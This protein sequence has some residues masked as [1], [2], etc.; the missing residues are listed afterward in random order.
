MFKKNQHFRRLFLSLLSAILTW[1]CIGTVTVNAEPRV[2]STG[3]SLVIV[4]DPG[5]GGVNEG[6]TQNGFLEKEMTLATANAM[7]DELIKYDN[8]E[9]YMTRTDDTDY[10]LK[11]RAEFAASVD[12]DFM[13]SLHYNASE[14]HTLF[15]S[16]IWISAFAPY[17]AYGYQFGYCY[18]KEMEELGIVLRGIKTRLGDD[19][20][21]YYGVIRE[22]AHLSVPAVIIEHCHVD[23]PRDSVYCA[24]K[25]DWERFGRADATA[26]AKYFGLSSSELGVDYS[27]ESLNLPAVKEN[28]KVPNTIRDKT[29]PDICSI[30]LIEAN[31]DTGEVSIQ[32]TATDYDSPLLYYDY[33]IDGG[34]TYSSMQPW[35]GTD[36]I[37][38]TSPDIINIDIQVPSGVQADVRVRAYNLAD[39]RKTSNHLPILQEFQY[40]E[41]SA[42]DTNQEAVISDAVKNEATPLP[43]PA[44]EKAPYVGTTTFFPDSLLTEEPQA[45]EEVSFITFLKICLVIVIVVFFAFIISQSISYE[46]RRKKRLQRRKELGDTQSQPK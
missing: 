27:E 43:S 36:V 1:F 17:N 30:E 10:S 29:A 14:F 32:V 42:L 19:G 2:Q 11:E 5:H 18:I 24:S 39:L 37:A 12:A 9:V 31:Y 34:K 26:V 15:G 45:E 33:S 44:L 21:D 22:S 20:D 35:P 8:I 4:I 16:E 28:V 46:L 6:T 13:F 40:E 23:E 41:A 7:Y 38:Y 3:D 25:E